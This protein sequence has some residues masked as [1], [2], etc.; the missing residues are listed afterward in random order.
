MAGPERREPARGETVA[1]TALC[2]ELPLSDCVDALALHRRARG[3]GGVLFARGERETDTLV[4]VRAP[5]RLTVRGEL[6]EVVA[7]EP[8][9]APLLQALA[10]RVSGSEVADLRLRAAVETA[11]RAGAVL[12]RDVLR[13]PSL[14]DPVRALLGLVVDRDEASVP[15]TACGAFAF[16]LVDRFDDL[17]ARRPDAFDEPDVDL[18]LGLDL[19][20]FDQ[21]SGVVQVVTR[22]LPWEAMTDVVARHEGLLTELRSAAPAAAE[23]APGAI[24]ARETERPDGEFVAGVERMREHI[25]AG[26]VFQAVLSRSVRWS[27]DADPLDV[28]AR[29]ASREPAPYRFH[30]ELQRGALFG[31]SPETCVRVQRGEVEIRPIAGTTLRGEDADTDERLALALLFDR[32]ERA[33]HVMLLD[34][35][36]NDVAR[37]AVPGSTRVVQQFAVEKYSRVQH[38]VSRVRG[39]LREDLDA[40]HAY[41][42]AANMGT[43]SGAPKPRAMEL[44]RALEPVGRGYYGG[45]VVALSA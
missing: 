37:V 3:R 22:G 4:L 26:D 23:A 42:A 1:S 28:F 43:L 10:T 2:A 19:V 20:R 33:E 6:V 12:D 14:F 9:A 18:L 29:L 13:E 27:G 24:G 44:I 41:R 7:R 45:A 34:L 16:D 40:L 21:A 32:K 30:L 25:A 15:V 8:G 17:G 11:P 38:L 35:A 5:L 36:R 39:T 31:S